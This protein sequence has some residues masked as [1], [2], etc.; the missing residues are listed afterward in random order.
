MNAQ[1][2][3]AGLTSKAI[4]LRRQVAQY[5]NQ[6]LD[7][8]EASPRYEALVRKVAEARGNYEL[9]VKKE[10]EARIAAAL[11]AQQISNVVLAE[12]PFVS[13]VPSA[14]N[15]RFGLMVAVLTATMLS[16][17]AAFVMD[18]V[19]LIYPLVWPLRVDTY[20]G[21]GIHVQT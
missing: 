21:P 4:E 6:V 20:T 5:R 2:E 16:V 3:L 18:H 17:C 19:A 13:R 9:Y 1:L 14:P 8:A 7:V 11:D 10:E 15:I 12:P